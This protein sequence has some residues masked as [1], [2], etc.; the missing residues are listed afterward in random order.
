MKQRRI[1]KVGML[2]AIRYRRP[3][4]RFAKSMAKNPKRTTRV[5]GSSRRAAIWAHQM[6]TNPKVQRHVKAAVIAASAAATRARKLGAARAATDQTFRDE[7]RTAAAAMASG[8]ATA[9]AP[10]KKRRGIAKLVF[11]IGMVLSGA[12]A[13]YHVNRSRSA[14]QTQFTYNTPDFAD[15]PS[16]DQPSKPTGATT[17]ATESGTRPTRPESEAVNS[18]AETESEYTE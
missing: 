15:S 9:Q 11:G 12:Y 1:A 10:K 8:I 13:G 14:D 17:A 5:N 4:L 2:A 6:R 16:R 18:P 3:L 7:L